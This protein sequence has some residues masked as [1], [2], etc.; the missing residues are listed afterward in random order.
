MARKPL[1]EQ[2]NTLEDIRQAAFRLFGRYGYEGVAM[3]VVAKEAGITKA[4]LYWHYK[5][6]SELFAD[7]LGRLNEIFRDY[8]FAPM[9]AAFQQNGRPEALAQDDARPKEIS[10]T[11]VGLLTELFRGMLRLVLD[12]RIRE[13]VAGYWQLPVNEEAV[14]AQEVRTRF[15]EEASFLLSLVIRKGI[16][17]GELDFKVQVEDMADAIISILETIILPLGRQDNDKIARMTG[18]L[19]YTFF[20]AHARD[21]ETADRVLKEINAMELAEVGT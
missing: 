20:K 7:C 6:K 8:I 15:E 13:G 5:S 17:D 10:P 19:A 14:V 21:P 18:A 4:S 11:A 1:S 16:E 12:R 3:S 2:G 9:T